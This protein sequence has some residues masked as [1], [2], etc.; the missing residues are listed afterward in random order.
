MKTWEDWQSLIQGGKIP[1][2]VVLCGEEH[3]LIEEALQEIRKRVLNP[4]VRDFNY[5]RL[6]GSDVS[7]RQVISTANMLPMMCERRLVEVKE[8]ESV[9]AEDNEWDVYLKSPSPTTVLVLL[10]G[11]LDQRSKIFKTF[12]KSADVYQFAA[13]KDP[14]AVSYVQ[15]YARRLNLQI[16][17]EA[18]QGLVAEVGCN[19]LLL[20]QAVIKLQLVSKSTITTQDIGDHIAS[21]RLED[22]FKLASA[23]ATAD[24]QEAIRLLLGLQ[25]DREQPIRLV[26]LLAWQLRQIVKARALLDQG[27]S[28]IEI[29]KSLAVYGERQRLLLLAA[30]KM[31]LAFHV[32]RLTKLSWLDKELKSSRA[33]SWDWMMR[34]VLQLCPV[35]KNR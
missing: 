3:A 16:E 18:A 26:G 29:G 14:Q 33:P 28:S 1:P 7:V 10:F 31:S 35:R 13:L 8:A 17:R 15:A 24:R 32:N 2:V 20:Q 23:I 34:V 9:S 6:T 27:A 19:L 22:A 5:D 21:T 25:E 11:Q 30:Q 12:D 4:A